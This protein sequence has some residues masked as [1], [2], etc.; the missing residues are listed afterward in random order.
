MRSIGVKITTI[1]GIILVTLF[2]AFSAVNYNEAKNKTI[3]LIDQ[4]Q[5]KI[6]SGAITYLEKYMQT[7]T[8]SIENL[9]K[10]IS[11]PDILEEAVIETAKIVNDTSGFDLVFVG[12]ENGRM[13]RSN[14]KH[15]FPQDG[16]DPRARDWYKQAK[17]DQK[18]GISDAY[19][20]STGQK[21]AIS[22]IAPIIIDG[23]FAGVAASDAYIGDLSNELLSLGKTKN[24]SLF[25]LDR[26]GRNLFHENEKARMKE[27]KN[28]NLILSSSEKLA[29]FNEDG[30]NVICQKTADNNYAICSSFNESAYKMH[31]EQLLQKEFLYSVVFIV[32]TILILFF[33]IKFYLS[34][35]GKIQSGL[36]EFFSFLNHKSKEAKLID[37]KGNDEISSMAKVINENIQEVQENMQEEN[38]FINE[39]SKFVQ[40]IQKGNY[41]AEILAK[42]NNASLEK[43]KS[44]LIGGVLSLRENICKNAND[45]T[46]AIESFA[47]QDFTKRL[48]D[49]AKFAKGVNL[50][51]IEISKILQSSLNQGEILQAK[52]I[53]LSQIVNEI[54]QASLNQSEKLTKSSNSVM[55]ITQ[56]MLE[57]NE[58]TENVA[59]Q[60]EDIKN[61]ISIIKDIADQT[62]LLALNAAIE[63]ARAG[64]HGRGF[65]V[66]AD[67]V[68]QLAERTQKSLNEIESS[69]NILVQSIIEISSF[70]KE[71]SD[72]IALIN[73]STQE[74]NELVKQNLN[75]VNQADAISDEVREMAK[76]TVEE[77]KK[78][79]F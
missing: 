59:K 30:K 14:G 6:L 16:Y 45:I 70:S 4:E 50:L 39:V 22:F 73:E 34:S 35:L 42:T 20:T 15:Q 78:K 76:L 3:E 55:Q 1:L 11:K 27:N 66:V 63:A 49:N 40:E 36:D 51:G 33:I 54:S 24:S 62:N 41:E 69:T 8:K 60:S 29:H 71:Q 68:R 28:A 46:E 48:E 44:A 19:I 65:A 38:S 37:I 52:S 31:T 26:K 10:Y 58:K 2:V 13:L 43:L 56:N 47:K 25:V 61:I 72:T 12:Y 5:K 57:M 17:A 23:K 53:S 7:N 74:V 21:L 79:K 75:I 9:A 18:A 67:E 77:A 64:E 32:V